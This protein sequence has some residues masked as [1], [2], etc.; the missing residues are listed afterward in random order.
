LVFLMPAPVD[1]KGES[2]RPKKRVETRNRKAPEIQRKAPSSAPPRPP[3]P[4]GRQQKPPPPP[5]AERKPI[6]VGGRRNEFGTR[7]SRRIDCSRC[8]AEDHVPYVPKNEARVL[9]RSC[10]KEVLAAYEVGQ[11][12]KT[13]TRAES[14]NLCGAPFQ[15][16]TSVPDDGDPLCP[17]CLRGFTTWS[18]SLD[19]P[20]EERQA[21][22]MEERRP[23][24][25]VRKKKPTA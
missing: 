9:C 12:V 18:G 8:G 10:A 24:L 1:P 21:T 11:K 17:S 7:I 23:G 6:F 20:W 25:V 16:P 15:M 19:T 4:G 2:A 14:C 5:D 3:P 13:P 22:V